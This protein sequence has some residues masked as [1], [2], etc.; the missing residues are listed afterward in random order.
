MNRAHSEPDNSGADHPGL[1]L[2]RHVLPA[3]KLSVSEAARELGIARQTLHR[4]MAGG[5]PITPE[6]AVRLERLCGI[7]SRFW[8]DRQRRYEL[9]RIREEIAKDLSRIPSHPL[10]REVLVHIGAGD[11]G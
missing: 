6:M 5:A 2:R 10:P 4:I 7:S 11:E 3:L 8:L 9:P 1:L